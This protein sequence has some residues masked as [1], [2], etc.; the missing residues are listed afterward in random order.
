MTYAL[1]T[2]GSVK[3]FAHVTEDEARRI[4]TN[5]KSLEIETYVKA[6][7][8]TGLRQNEVLGLKV[9]DLKQ[10]GLDFAI[11]VTRSKRRSKVDVERL[12]IAREL[13][14]ALTT[15]AKAVKLKPTNLFFSKHEN[16]YRYQLRQSAKRAGLE[17]WQKVHPHMFRH[18][19]C[20]FHVSRGVHPYILS[21]LMGHGSLA[22]TLQYFSPSE[23]DLRRAIE[24]GATNS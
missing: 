24:R 15:Y 9:A 23:H 3:T 18:G 13:G 11:M 1:T 16:D 4:W 19:F 2:S 7:W 6:L 12:P 20:Y 10:D 8:H 14:E 22:I 5:A 17:S 21:R